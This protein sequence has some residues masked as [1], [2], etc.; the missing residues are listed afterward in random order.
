MKRLLTAILLTLPAFAAD[1]RI[2]DAAALGNRDT[3]LTLIKANADVNGAQGDG[4]TALHWAAMHDDLELARTLLAKGANPQ[5]VTRLGGMTPLLLAAKSGSTALVQALLQGGASVKQADQL[6]VTPL[7][8]AAAGG[9]AEIVKALVAGGADVNATESA[10]GQT[11]LMFAAAYNRAGA[12]KALLA[13]GGSTRAYTQTSDPGCGSTFN[14]NACED[15]DADEVPNPVKPPKRDTAKDKVSEPMPKKEGAEAEKQP[16][17]RRGA[18][19][20]GG[21]TPLLFAARDGQTEAAKALVEG[22]ADVN[23]AGLGEK[24]TPLVIAIA[25]GHYDLAMYFLE[26]KADPNP[27]SDS[28][29]TALYAAIDMQWAPYAWYP[30]PI[31][32]QE[33]TSYLDLMKAL[34][35]KGANVNARLERRVWFR[36]LVGDSSWVDQAGATPFWRAAQS[37]DLAAMELLVANGADPV[38]ATTAG[39]TPLMVTAGVGWAMNFSRNAP[40]AWMDSVKFCLEHGNDVNAAD[41]R[42]YTALHGAAFRGDNDLINFLISKGAKI[43]A[44]T[45]TGDT[46]ADMANGPIPH[47]IPH[48]ETVA[49]LEKLGS[50]NSHNCRS[51]QCL[52]AP[53]SQ[54]KQ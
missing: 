22:G 45:K 12:V 7:M 51:D 38:L 32:A 46:V 47:S 52:I 25:N 39:S 15:K 24:M 8:M 21:M 54:P 5:T 35:A 18:A 20:T 28:G 4:M 10:H 43:D 11:A 44:K 49:L 37:N 48:P 30:Q 23:D 40:N 29:L 14:R 2:A 19:I 6:G 27:A 31:T 53:T 9:N 34:I 3:A 26:H 50:A 41:T 36:A 16:K 42:G 1:S 17:R 13:A 33:K